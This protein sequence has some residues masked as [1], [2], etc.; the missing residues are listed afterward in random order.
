MWDVCLCVVF[1]LKEHDKLFSRHN[2]SI[3]QLNIMIHLIYDAE[4]RIFRDHV[5]LDQLPTS[6]PSQCIAHSP[7]LLLY[8]FHVHLWHFPNT[9]D[10]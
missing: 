9:W 5:L 10:W 1:H 4:N 3:K 2:T 8:L 6:K 7:V